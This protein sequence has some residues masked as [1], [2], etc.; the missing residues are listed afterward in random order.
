[1]PLPGITFT[2]SRPQ[3]PGLSSRADVAI[4]VGC[5]ARR[6][7]ALPAGVREAL[8][9][10]GWTPTGVF[11]AAAARMDSLLGLPVPVESWSEFDALYAWDQRPMG[12]GSDQSVPC[13]LGLAVRRFFAEGGAKA[14]VV[15]T[16]DPIALDD[17]AAGP[18]AF[19]KAKRLL[20]AWKTNKPA[21]AALRQPLLA[22]LGGLGS[23]SDPADPA[24][25]TGAAVAYAVEDAALLLLPDLIDLCA[26]APHQAPPPQEPPG[27]PEIFKPC[28]PAA[29]ELAPE[30]RVARPAL[31]APRLDAE[32]Y[33]MWSRATRFALDLL[34]RPKG[35]A[36][37]RDLTLV[38]AM[39][40]PF[41]AEGGFSDGEECW[42]LALLDRPDLAGPGL[43]LLDD[44]AVG[45]ARLQLA[46]P[47]IATPDSVDLPEGLESPEGALAAVIARSAIQRGAF[48]SAA[49]EPLRSVTALVPEIG[50][51]DLARGLPGKADWL[52]DRLSLFAVRR[53][54]VELFSDSSMA[55]QRAW[56]PGGTSRL[57]GILL[58]AS[59]TLGDDLVFEPAGPILWGRMRAALEALCDSLRALG[60]FAGRSRDEAFTVSCDA[61]TMTQSDIDNG[62]VIATL[63]FLPAQPIERI[64][65]VLQLIEAASATTREAA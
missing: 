57:M 65:V 59:R 56:R 3:A 52:G 25:W 15:R 19:T 29:P 30:A 9:A 62:R 60:A 43:R 13:P 58:R 11:K 8:K 46:Y 16:G 47:W 36:H 20:L 28:A 53:G 26:G 33:A 38:S 23:P 2:T 24:T 49:G 35:P 22:G 18:E 14:Y 44:G 5:V 10:D 51:S 4:F 54:R 42:P 55:P 27:P 31:L 50:A 45:N 32:G 7:A 12:P 61:S 34:G 37:R 40:L 63:S 21:D 64:T 41:V 17:A 39:P 1:M 48:R 6:A